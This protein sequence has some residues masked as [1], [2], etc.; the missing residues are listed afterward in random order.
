MPVVLQA[1]ADAAITDSAAERARRERAREGASGIVGYS[2]NAEMTRAVFG[3]SGR[4][5]LADLL[6]G[7]TTEVRVTASH[8]TAAIFD[9]QISPDGKLVA[10][11]RATTLCLLV[12]ASSDSTE[13]LT[14]TIIASEENPLASDDVI[15]GQADFIAAE[16]MSRSRGF[17]WAPDSQ[18][19]AVCR[20]DSS[21]V[22]KVA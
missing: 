3:V 17:W 14:E 1:P 18:T 9:P 5:F 13:P 11:A 6:A 16:E 10:Y 7:N 22:A 12:L 8:P 4:L 20:V 21:A 15:W 19:L 2:V